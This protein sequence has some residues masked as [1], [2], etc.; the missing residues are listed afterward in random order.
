MRMDFAK[1]AENLG[2]EEDEYLELWELFLETSSSD[3]S[4]LQSAID[5]GDIQQTVEAA[6][7]V[8]GAAV[9]LGFEEIYEMAKGVE[10]KARENSLDGVTEPVRI[11]RKKLDVMGEALRSG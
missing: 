9:T 1:L 4:K 6:H 5:R 7:S 10:E 3:L 11:M 2:L 8:K